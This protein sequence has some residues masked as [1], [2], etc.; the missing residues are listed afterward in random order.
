MKKY[1]F[2]H[3][4]LLIGGVIFSIVSALCRVVIPVLIGNCVDLMVG[5][6]N[7]DFDGVFRYVMI[8]TVIVIILMIAQYCSTTLFN[9]LN[10]QV[11]KDIRED[12]FEK[13]Q[14]LPLSYLDSH[15]HG[16]T[17]NVAINDTEAFCEGMLLCFNS[18]FSGIITI[19]GIIIF[20]F[21]INVQIALVVIVLTPVS[22]MITRYVANQTHKL[23]E[24]QTKLKAA[25]SALVDENIQNQKIVKSLNYQNTSIDKFR[26][27]NEEI[28]EY[29]SKATFYSSLVNPS[30]RFINNCI[31]ALTGLLGAIFAI[32]GDITLGSVS[33]F[34]SYANEFGK[35]FNDI[36]SVLS[37]LQSSLAS[38]RRINELLNAEEDDLSQMESLVTKDGSIE[39]KNVDF[40]YVKGKKVIDDLSL[41]IKPNERIAIVG[42]TGCGKTTLIN[43]LL[44]FYE[45]DS[46]EILIDNQNIR[47]YSKESLRSKF[48]MVLQDSW[49][50]KASVRE[51]LTIGNEYIS[52]EELKKICKATYCD[53]FISKL[54]DKYD[55]IIDND[56]LSSGQK[57]LLSIARVMISN[58]GILILDEATS[59]IDTLTEA[60]V[61]KALELLMKDKTSIVVAHR[62]STIVNSDRIVVMDKGR[63]AECG[64]HEEL[65]KLNGI[66]SELVRSK[67][68]PND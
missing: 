28:R 39:F 46:G 65:M 16:E 43:L 31:Y 10:F 64:N 35:P 23:F 41:N 8:I 33:V 37:E 25:Q 15:L 47:E 20:M 56:S 48:G 67:Q 50:K 66:Y 24:K 53:S 63:I 19:I 9:H 58:P 26:D 27:V 30:T 2:N 12:I 32:R 57:Q 1:F 18:L 60:K 42:K 36:T 6:G 62:L 54:K 11:N 22:L 5:V 68:E 34:L 59:N 61:Q 51:N 40:S 4:F 17:I 52:D 14:R 38:A 7:V 45:I 55:S 13:I 3:S 49:I 21:R 29:V 44:R